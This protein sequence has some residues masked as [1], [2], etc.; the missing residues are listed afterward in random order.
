MQALGENLAADTPLCASGGK[1][2]GSTWQWNLSYVRTHR[3]EH[4]IGENV[5][6]INARTSEL[7]DDCRSNLQVCERDLSQLGYNVLSVVGSPHEFM[8]PQ[9]RWR[10]F[11]IFSRTLSMASLKEVAS[12]L[13]AVKVAAPLLP[14][15]AFTLHPDDPLIGSSLDAHLQAA[16]HHAESNQRAKATQQ[17]AKKDRRK[18][19]QP[20]NRYADPQ[21]ASQL[22]WLDTLTPRE[23]SCLTSVPDSAPARSV[24]ISQDKDRAFLSGPDAAA[25]IQCIA[26][27]ARI[28]DTVLD[29]LWVPHELCAFKGI[30]ISRAEAEKW[31][32]DL[33]SDLAGNAFCGPL[34]LILIMCLIIA[35]AKQRR[36]E[37]FDRVTTQLQ[38]DLNTAKDQTSDELPIYVDGQCAE[39]NPESQGFA[40]M[41]DFGLLDEF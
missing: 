11:I 26:K 29:R 24:D 8:I 40:G 1:N 2:S 39:P 17:W 7:P 13:D 23:T 5:L 18:G 38:V 27:V 30:L 19:A 15:D 41:A 4:G 32:A 16:A 22:P 35:D 14:V 12:T 31:D 20:L 6:N 37:D 9:M 21:L 34:V 33:L 25:V 28:W 3:P 10:V 36:A